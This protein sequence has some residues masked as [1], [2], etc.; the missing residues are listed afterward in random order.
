[1][2]EEKFMRKTIGLLL[3]GLLLAA[4]AWAWS[5]HALITE[6]VF[7]GQLPET[8]VKTER[9]ETF[10]RAEAPAIERALAAE[11]LWAGRNLPWYQPLP[12]RLKF[13]AASPDLRRSFTDAIRINPQARLALY[14]EEL[15]GRPSRRP[16]LAA[17]AV[18]IFSD[19]AELKGVRLAALSEG[20]SVRPL[21]VL[22][23]ASD[24]PDRGLDVNLFTDNAAG[25]DY[26]FGRQPY[27][28]PN[29]GYGSQAPFHM[30]FYH[31]P[32]LVYRLGPFMRQS[33]AEMRVHQYKTLARLAFASGHPYWG[34]R[35]TGLGLHYLADL[36]QPYHSVAL[37]G[38]S[39][40]RMMR[41]ELLNACGRGE[42]K[43]QAVQLVSNRHLALERFERCLLER[44]YQ[45]GGRD[46]EQF[47][48]LRAPGSTPVYTDATIRT[49]LTVQASR[50]A[51][52]ID[53]LLVE[54]MPARLVSDPGFE[55]DGSSAERDLL[56][57]VEREKGAEAVRNLEAA[58]GELL[59]PFARY[60]RAYVLAVRDAAP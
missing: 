51:V 56:E 13:S 45:A 40:S 37:P 26:G 36:A 8:P 41:L 27:G 5:L 3:A 49:E 59:K 17:A 32:W 2:H 7:E 10:L 15:S 4:P 21:D 38:V 60:G 53:R 16:A 6:P 20:E 28:N 47:R 29:L 30:G 18:S 1:M 54:N 12:A 22:V 24:E 23:T 9:L 39:L 31:E 44:A 19:D 57:L 48:Q 25:R 42:A 14:L 58:M 11:E 35:F 46:Y 34:W 33:Y 52:A 55:F 43:R 50:Q